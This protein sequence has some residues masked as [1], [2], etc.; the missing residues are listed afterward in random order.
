[1]H[2][3][4][5]LAHTTEDFLMQ[6]LRCRI[7]VV[8]FCD[9]CG[10]IHPNVN[11]FAAAVAAHVE[12]KSAWISARCTVLIPLAAPEELAEESHLFPLPPAP[13][14]P[15]C[16]DP[17]VDH[18]RDGLAYTIPVPLFTYRIFQETHGFRHESNRSVRRA[19]PGMGHRNCYHVGV[20]ARGGSNARHVS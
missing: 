13:L 6:H 10:P 1:M 16:T 18:S 5:I 15:C 12:V 7:S 19:A 3:H 20:V 17:S 9:I 4:E 11:R 8:F 14:I 2:V